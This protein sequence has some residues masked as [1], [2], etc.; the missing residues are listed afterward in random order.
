MPLKVN[1]KTAPA[2]FTGD[3]PTSNT[4]VSGPSETFSKGLRRILE[5]HGVEP[6]KSEG[7]FQ[8]W[9]SRPTI[10]GPDACLAEYIIRRHH[11]S[12]TPET[13][14]ILQAAFDAVEDE[15]GL[16]AF[17][18][19]RKGRSVGRDPLIVKSGSLDF[20]AN[21]DA[22]NTTRCAALEAAGWL[23]IEDPNEKLRASFGTQPYKTR[24]PFVAEVLRH[25][26]TPQAERL[27]NQQLSSAGQAIKLSKSHVAPAEFNV[28]AP[29]GQSYL[30]FQAGGIHAL[31]GARSGIIADDMGLGKTIQGVGLINAR[32]D[33]ENVLVICQANMKLKWKSE[34]EKWR[35]DDALD[36]GVASGKTVPTD[37]IVVINYDILSENEQKLRA[38]AWD[39]IICDEA[40]NLKNEEALRTRAVLGDLLDEEGAE[41]LPLAD[42]GQLVHLSGTP[43]PNRTSEMWPLLTSTRP[44][45]WG[46]GP[47]AREVFI[48]RYQPPVLIK[49]S[50][51]KGNRT[52]ER[53]IPMAGKPRRETE[54][55]LRLRGSGSFIRRL[56]R[57]L[58]LPPKFRTPLELPFRLS[59]EEKEALRDIETD[60]QD[61]IGRVSGAEIKVGD[62]RLAGAVIDTITR[63]DPDSPDITEMSRVRR[64]LGILKAP[65]CARFI[66]DELE[67]EEQLAPELRTKTVVFAHHREVIDV[68]MAEAEK[69]MKG[70]FLRYD[71]TLSTDK[72]R[73]AAVDRFQEDDTVRAMVI[74]L[75]GATGITLVKSARMRVVEPDWKPANMVQIEDR[76]WR[77]G[78]ERNV[79]IG[80]L[81]VPGSMD[82]R[83]G[84][85]LIE[86][87]ES[88]ERAINEITFRHDADKPSAEAEKPAIKKPSHQNEK[89]ETEH[90]DREGQLSFGL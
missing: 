43:R 18:G 55:Q 50:F 82:A 38:R 64:N 69:R 84:N 30:P 57:D 70:A 76:I 28:L 56:K 59:R 51:T 80:Y 32:T 53:I 33:L 2:R 27:L 41:M 67:E 31:S 61:L 22:E 47:K 7:G 13:R 23:P 8:I 65:H 63:I 75:A 60:M 40:H 4:V 26:M 16:E 88:D 58:D 21:C 5:I 52:F 42:G 68:I 77:I 25:R 81:S 45:L 72:K 9:S 62:A 78:Q 6:F 11:V 10:G 66:I 29:D 90:A 12:P 74:S 89:P 37:P 44:D 46:K 83:I 24:D 20:V 73:Q 71:G 48:N 85:A 17:L 86:K 34:I 14:K 79:D 1:L 15:D 3:K 19:R 36:V 87:M 39:M 35:L 54:L 49:K